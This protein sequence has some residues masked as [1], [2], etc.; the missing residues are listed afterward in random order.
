MLIYLYHVILY[1][2]IST[3]SYYIINKVLAPHIV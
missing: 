2:F 1:L 3:Q